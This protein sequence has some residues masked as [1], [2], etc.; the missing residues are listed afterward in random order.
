[1]ECLAALSNAGAES[2]AE[3]DTRYTRPEAPFDLASTGDVKLISYNWLVERA[4]ARKPLPRRQ[5]LPA[6]AF[7]N[8]AELRAMH[9]AAPPHVAAAVL[10]LVSV[11]YC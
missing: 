7:A 1:M 2:N 6:E 4:K 8:V 3:A 10:P 5:E 9:A 11:S